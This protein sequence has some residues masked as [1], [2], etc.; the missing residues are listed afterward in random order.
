MAKESKQTFVVFQDWSNYILALPDEDALDLS[1]AIFAAGVGK[2]YTIKNDAVRTYF[3][4]VILP[5]MESNRQARNDFRDKQAEYGRKG[6]KAKAEKS[7]VAKGS[8]GSARVAKGSQGFVANNGDGNGDG[9]I[10]PKGDNSARA[11]EPLDPNASKHD[12]NGNIDLNE[13]IQD[14]DMRKALA[15]YIDVR[16]D[17][18]PY[19]YGSIAETLSSAAAA[20]QKYGAPECIKVIKQATRGAWKAIRWEDLEKA[21]S[22]TTGS[23]FNSFEQ[24]QY[25]WDQLEG[26]LLNGTG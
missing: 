4:A 14:P 18:G 3:E 6:G 23:G 26:V 17:V 13:I 25:D 21:R 12:P 20:E 15:E 16:K 10:S 8:L 22:G 1:R 2:E 9:D 5:D 7:M 24:H 11:R 19:P